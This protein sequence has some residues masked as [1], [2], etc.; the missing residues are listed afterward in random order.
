MSNDVKIT[1]R[2]RIV[3]KVA[4]MGPY[5]YRNY[6]IQFIE[7]MSTVAFLASD[8]RLPG[9]Q[10]LEDE[11]LAYYNRHYASVGG[12]VSDILVIY[13][14]LLT[15]REGDATWADYNLRKLIEE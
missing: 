1:N 8:L 14:D 3:V 15:P 9:Q 10:S 7:P 12:P 6:L 11:L 2:D 4:E 5:T 13:C